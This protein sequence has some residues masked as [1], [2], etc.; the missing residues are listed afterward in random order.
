MI[1]EIQIDEK[2]EWDAAVKGFEKYDVFYLNSYAKAFQNEGE[3]NPVL[4]YVE[5]SKAK[6]VNVIMKRDIAE[7]AQFQGKLEKG[8]YFDISSPYGYGGFMLMGDESSFQI[9][10]KEYDAYCAKNRYV[11]EFVRFELMEPYRKYYTGQIETRTH[12]IVRS[13][14]GTMEEIFSN[15]E[16]K[17][18]KNYRKAQKNGLEIMIDECGEKLDDFLR[19]YYGTMERTEAEEA[20]FFQESFFKTL[21]E[22]RE[23]VCYFHVLYEGQVI[24]TEL[25]IYGS[26]NAYSYL[27]GTDS[28]YFH[29]R[30]ND[31]LKVEIIKWA[32]EKG[33]RNFVLGG[34]YGSD[35]GIYRYK[36]SFAPEGEMDFYIGKRIFDKEKY[37]QFTRMNFNL[38]EMDSDFF[39]L[40]RTKKRD[41]IRGIK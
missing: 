3:G 25:V 12:N 26:E 16:H 8:K 23:N 18:R 37:D 19:I 20:F 33:L 14:E 15:F 21:N 29:V 34:G 38:I 10:L 36:K 6:A 7:C 28:H 9:I 24:S 5:C 41:T 22:M 39:P 32:K 11:S 27:G 13:L 1:R 35:D 4:I 40:Y 31:F 17:V 2:E 30:P